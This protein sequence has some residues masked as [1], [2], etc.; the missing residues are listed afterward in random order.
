MTSFSNCNKKNPDLLVIGVE[1]LILNV[2]EPFDPLAG[3]QLTALSRQIIYVMGHQDGGHY[4]SA[5]STC[6]FNNLG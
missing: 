1:K 3:L 4:Q 2:T 6:P 5:C